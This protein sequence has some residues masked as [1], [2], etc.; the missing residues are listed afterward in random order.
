M[1][2]G[3]GGTL[4]AAA[5]YGVVALSRTALTMEG[6]SIAVLPSLAIASIGIALAVI[7]SGAAAVVPAALA[8]RRPIVA[9]FR[10]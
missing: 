9:G 7:L 2:G 8:A 1:L 4:G 10:A 3:I 6:V 5:S